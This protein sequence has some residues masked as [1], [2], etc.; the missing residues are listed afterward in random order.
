MERL[1]YL[2]FPLIL[3]VVSTGSFLL[4]DRDTVPVYGVEEGTN[5]LKVAWLLPSKE[6]YLVHAYGYSW[7]HPT[8][9]GRVRRDLARRYLRHAGWSLGFGLLSAC[10]L[11]GILVL[12]DPRRKARGEHE[13][14]SHERDAALAPDDSVVVGER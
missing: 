8:D 12:F 4:M 14:G 5:R 7:N 9:P 13:G 1:H 10:V 6:T 3:L 11:V 2:L